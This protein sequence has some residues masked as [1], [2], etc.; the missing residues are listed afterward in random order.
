MGL[1][2]CDIVYLLTRDEARRV[3]IEMVLG[4]VAL[5]F[6]ASRPAGLTTPA[7]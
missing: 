7:T 6:C 4:F 3:A 1:K 2:A 5:N